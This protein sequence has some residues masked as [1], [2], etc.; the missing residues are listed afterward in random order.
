[1]IQ[2]PRVEADVEGLGK[3][4]VCEY[5]PLD[6]SL[7]KLNHEPLI[8]FR[9]LA[10]A[11]IKEGV[12][13]SL[14][15]ERGL[16]A[17]ACIRIPNGP[18]LFVRDSPILKD[19]KRA[20]DAETREEEF[21][22]TQDEVNFYLEQAQEDS[23]KPVQKRRVL[24]IPGRKE[25]SRKY[26]KR[27]EGLKSLSARSDNQNKD[28]IDIVDWTLQNLSPAY[29]RFV[30]ENKGNLFIY[31]DDQERDV[32]ISYEENPLIKPFAKQM[33]YSSP[34]GIHGDTHCLNAGIEKVRIV[35]K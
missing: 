24:S 9:D 23:Q 7:E 22:L 5:L 12:R 19:A 10:Y 14:T 17:E 29:Q 21:Y 26:G 16:V 2:T 25:V 34:W 33:S 4:V 35:K 31:L 15:K 18:A 11:Q 1:M 13:T 28:F 30:A 20:L 32:D 3:I 27:T 6:E 8:N